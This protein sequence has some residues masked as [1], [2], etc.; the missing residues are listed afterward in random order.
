M[1]ALVVT[2]EGRLT[3]EEIDRPEISERQALVKTVSCGICGTDATIIRQ[4]FKGFKPSHYPLVLGHEGVGEVVE[5]GAAVKSFKQRPRH[6]SVRPQSVEGRPTPARRMGAFSEYGIVDDAAAYSPG[7]APEAAAAQQK[8]PRFIDKHEAPVLVTLREVLST[9]RYFG[10]RPGESVVV[11]GSGPVAM[12]FVKLLRLL[13]VDEV[14]AVVRSAKKAELMKEFGAAACI[15]STEEDVKKQIRSHYPNGVAYVLDAVGSESI[16]N[17]GISLLRDRGEI[18]CYGVP[19]VNHMEL[20][21]TD[22]PYNWKLNF[23]Q[24]PY[25]EEEAAC[26]E[27]V[28]E[29][30]A[31]GKLV[32]SDFIS[33][34]VGFES[35]LDAFQEYLDGKTM[36]KVIITF[37]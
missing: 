14:T 12:T 29:W 18:L 24:M 21:W 8:L 34:M 6:P 22:A 15:V 5:V 36:K 35:V 37:E 17:E 32:L 25:K 23:Q 7:E 9:I 28:L 26:H 30:V 16:I 31:D 20:D 11:Y 2:E 27:Q 13:G 10:I 19:K 3:V 4:A 1:K 33:K